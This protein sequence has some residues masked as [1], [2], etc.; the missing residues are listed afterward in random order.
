MNKPIRILWTLSTVFLGLTLITSANASSDIDASD[1]EKALKT[2][3]L[4]KCDNAQIIGINTFIKYSPW[5]V[6]FSIDDSNKMH[7]IDRQKARFRHNGTRLTWVEAK[8][9]N[10]I[11]I[12]PLNDREIIYI[13]KLFDTEKTIKTI[14]TVLSR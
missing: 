3:L 1:T 7:L 11:Q 6:E 8:S 5:F 12:D 10:Q 2:S 14:C 4:F 9:E 13:K